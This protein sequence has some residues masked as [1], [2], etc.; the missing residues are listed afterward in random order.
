MRRNEGRLS[1]AK[2]TRHFSAALDRRLFSSPVYAPA[3]HTRLESLPS[4]MCSPVLRYTNNA[5]FSIR[6]V[7]TAYTAYKLRGKSLKQTK[8]RKGGGQR[9]RYAH[10]VA[11]LTRNSSLRKIRQSPLY[12]HTHTGPTSSRVPLAEEHRLS[13]ARFFVAR[14]HPQTKPMPYVTSLSLPGQECYLMTQRRE[15]NTM[16]DSRRTVLPLLETR[17]HVERIPRCAAGSSDRI[18]C[19]ARGCSSASA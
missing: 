12:A 16:I 11:V 7:T 4:H 6:L 14:Q 5:F 1:S 10:A 13:S 2:Y 3:R 17:S 8:R 9:T 18:R 15:R 19:S